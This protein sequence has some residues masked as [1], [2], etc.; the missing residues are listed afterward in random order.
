MFPASPRAN[1]M[2]KLLKL[3]L[4]ECGAH[5]VVTRTHPHN[6]THAGM[7]THTHSHTRTYTHTR[8]VRAVVAMSVDV[9]CMAL[10]TSSL[11]TRHPADAL[12]LFHCLRVCRV[13]STQIERSGTVGKR[14]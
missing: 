7:H 6:R 13:K 3:V 8:S 5:H 12:F 2:S 11:N 4:L 9:T 10:L 1:T 14:G